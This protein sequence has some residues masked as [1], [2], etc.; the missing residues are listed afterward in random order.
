[1]NQI[2]AQQIR[3]PAEKCVLTTQIIICTLRGDRFFGD[4]L[5]DFSAPG[6]Q[7]NAAIFVGVV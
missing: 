6:F 2:L 3:W 5:G 1:M 4:L 7:D